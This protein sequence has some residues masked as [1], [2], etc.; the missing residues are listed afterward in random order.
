MNDIIKEK[1]F[2]LGNE[3]LRR[4]KLILYKHT[5]SYNRSNKYGLRSPF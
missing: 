3:Q 4:F 2:K 1:S 5:V